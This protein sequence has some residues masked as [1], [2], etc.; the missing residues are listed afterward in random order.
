MSDQG[1]LFLCVANSARSQMAEGLAHRLVPPGIQVYSAGSE[2]GSVNP[3]AVRAMAEIGVDISGHRSKSV[4]EIPVDRVEVVVTLCAEEVCPVF[5]GP[6]R[7]LHWPVDD[8]ARAGGSEAERL[9]AFRQA[10]DEIARRLQDW[11][12]AGPPGDPSA[13]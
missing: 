12:G 7:R 11:L 1:I 3:L 2:P 13:A 4:D 5:P 8:P 6:V 9:E 10:R